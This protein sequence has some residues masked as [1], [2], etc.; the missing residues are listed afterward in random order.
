MINLTNKAGESPLHHATQGGHTPVVDALLSHGADINFL[1]AEGQ[2][3]LH[4]AAELCNKPDVKVE[5]T[6]TLTQVQT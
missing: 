5:M 3:C 2:S 6:S 4:L 1:T